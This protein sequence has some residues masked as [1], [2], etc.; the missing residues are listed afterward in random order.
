MQKLITFIEE[1][2]APPLIR[3]SQIRYLDAVQKAFMSFMP[4]LLISSLFILIAALPIPGWSDIVAPIAG[5]LW[6]AVNA[7][8]GVI[9]IGIAASLGY[10]LG[11]Y[12][13]AKDSRIDRLSTTLV[14]VISFLALFPLTVT[15]DG[16]VFM[17]ATYFGSAGLFAAIIVSI[18][19]VEIYRLIVKANI[20]IKMP[21]EVPPMVSQAFTSVIPAAIVVT[22]WWVVSQIIG[23]DVPGFVMQVF[24]TLVSA[25]TTAVSQFIAFMLDRVLWFVGIHGSNVVGSVL[26]PVWTQMISDNMAAFQA[27]DI[28]PY[29]F[30]EQWTNYF[31]RVSVVPL[32]LLMI[33]SKVR[34]YKTLGALSFA[35]AIFNIAEP[36]MFGLPI[37]LN[38]IMFIP[39][40]FG[41]GFIWTLT[42]VFTA[43]FNLIPP[44]IALVPWT[45]PGPIAAY[46]GTG[47]S[48]IAALI[49]C[50]NYV[51]MFFIWLPF[52]KVLERQEMK[53]E[54][55]ARAQ[56]EL[57]EAAKVGEVHE[58]SS[59]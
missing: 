14:A 21:K 40:V 47:G 24:S 1:K 59:V 18:L 26:S 13:R 3:V 31:I 25:G 45:V 16:G 42:Y 46:L 12:Y 58:T 8:M 19:S 20:T 9:S 11:D 37:V 6:G 50:L 39:W 10:H 7:T 49:S 33:F 44:I 38:P 36:V 27:G 41:Y 23:F 30:T 29:L 48:I 22:L 35:P 51:L 32:V 15:D 2:L 56:E 34:R 52:F 17:S 43:V 53:V 5:K 54:A 57:E 55:E 4:Y 28:V